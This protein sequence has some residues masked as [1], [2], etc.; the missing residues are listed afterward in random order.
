MYLKNSYTLY[1]LLLAVIGILFYI[2]N[3][4][5]PFIH[6]D[7]AYCFYYAKD[8]YIIRP[9]SIG[10]TGFWQMLESM[11]H[12]YLCV[13]GRFISHL[14]LQTFCAFLGKDVFNICNTGI[15]LI[16]LH[17]IVLLSE[18]KYSP[19]VLLL[20]FLSSFCIFPFPG[21]TMLWMTGSL[22][23]LWPMTF[24]LLYLYWIGKY[25]RQQCSNLG[26]LFTAFVG[27]LISWTQESISAPIALGLTVY[28]IWN[29]EKLEGYIRSSLIGYVI[30][31]S[32]IV[33][34]PGTFSRTSLGNE[35]SLEMDAIQFVFLHSY[36]TIYQYFINIFPIIICIIY[37]FILIYKLKHKNGKSSFKDLYWNLLIAFTLFLFA[38][39]K[40]EERIFFGVTTISFV[41]ILICLK[42]VVKKVENNKVIICS[43]V[44]I[45]FIPSYY[46]IS[47]TQS[48]AKHNH[49][50]CNKIIQSPKDCILEANNYD[51][52]SR[53]VYVTNLDADRNNFHNRVMSFYYGK[54]FIQSLPK[55]LFLLTKNR[56]AKFIETDIY[57]KNQPLLE[58]ENSNYWLLPIKEQPSIKLLADYTYNNEKN[59][60]ITSLQK[61]IRYLLNTL[62]IK[63][64]TQKCF[65]MDIYNN[66]YLVL[67]KDDLCSSI[68]IQ[69]PTFELFQP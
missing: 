1:F 69:N 8:S 56:E 52:K 12:H 59:T 58:I 37:T 44:F 53:F 25:K 30:G 17:T 36:N 41:F 60:N 54:N 39:G 15:Y 45:C 64:R 18:H 4:N 7:Y 48:F 55:D 29:K 27:I 14:T 2:L 42:D 51:K 19:I 28:F 63:H 43:L 23:Y 35:I 61:V 33:F 16:F 38:L 3:I 65:G 11:W 66:H 32:L 40:D 34:A 67:P 62:N 49:A 13:N 31:A 46:A 26:Y 10:I 21:Q 6:D 57:Y 24:A 50:I 22:N 20:T 5:T 68:T 47:N 9:T